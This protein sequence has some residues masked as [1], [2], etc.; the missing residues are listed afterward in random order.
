MAEDKERW[1]KVRIAPEMKAAIQTTAAAN[2]VSMTHLVNYAMRCI[3]TGEAPDFVKMREATYAPPENPDRR[4]ESVMADLRDE[5][6]EE[7]ELE[8]FLRSQGLIDAEGHFI[9]IS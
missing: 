8:K 4:V 1:L 7:S 5:M 3:I 9:A 6:G 2:G